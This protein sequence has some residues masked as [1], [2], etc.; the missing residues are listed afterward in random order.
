MFLR[1]NEYRKLGS[2]CI[3]FLHGIGDF[4]MLTP[5]LKKIKALNPS[6]RT[7]V[8]LRK[9]LGLKAM[10]ENL[11]F[12][13]EVLELSLEK[14]PRFYVPWIYWTSEHWAIRKRLKELLRGRSFDRVKMVYNQL[15]PTV[16]YLVFCPKR[17]RT[18][19]IVRLAREL[20]VALTDDEM[21]RTFLNIPPE[22]ASEAR[23]A[24]RR[25]GASGLV[26]GIQRNTMDRT[27]F[28]PFSA[29]QD[30]VDRLNRLHGESGLFFLV[31]ADEQSYAL[32]E[33]MDGGH[34]KAPNLLYSG[35]LGLP[36][37]SMAL[38]ALVDCC[39]YVISVDS[40]VF[41]IACA[42][43]KNTIGIFNTYKVRSSERTLK[44]DNILC[45]DSPAVTAEDLLRMFHALLSRAVKNEAEAAKTPSEST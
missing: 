26:I 36:Q 17:V 5:A 21:N 41:N 20:G 25:R 6:V 35:S 38:A 31:F 24:L 33:R 28:I 34:L 30:F 32:E 43:G 29:V 27:R 2:V 22:A 40:S 42:L 15:M 44:R 45:M 3:V 16:V 18:H 4:V 8:V 10:A 11:G 9:E 23:E 39:G 14:H 12:V 7:T 1:E 13:D 37:D 19:K